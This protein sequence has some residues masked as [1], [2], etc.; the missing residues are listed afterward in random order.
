[1]MLNAITSITTQSQIQIVLRAFLLQI[2]QPTVPVIVGQDNRVP[3]PANTDFVLMTPMFRERIS[4]NKDLYPFTPSQDPITGGNNNYT[5]ST[6]VLIQCDVHGP[7]A[8]D[9]AEIIVTMLRDN[10]ATDF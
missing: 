1:M 5:Q 6:K 7:N 3:E 9:N 8:S 10:Y 2:L 4:T